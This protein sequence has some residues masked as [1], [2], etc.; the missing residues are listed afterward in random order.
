M[1]QM[2][3]LLSLPLPLPPPLLPLQLLLLLL[4]PLPPLPLLLLPAAIC[5]A[6]RQGS[7]AGSGSPKPDCHAFACDGP[8][9]AKRSGS[10]SSKSNGS[11]SLAKQAVRAPETT[12][13]RRAAKRASN[14]R[15]AG[16]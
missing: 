12:P 10:L 6:R 14:G 2:P 13:Q 1:L 11:R 15:L 7:L 9:H 5:R 16:V 4:L 3:V 8:A